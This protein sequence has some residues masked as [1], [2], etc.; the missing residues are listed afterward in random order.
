MKA[1]LRAPVEQLFLERGLLFTKR[2][3]TV[4][5]IFGVLKVF[6]GGVSYSDPTALADCL[7]AG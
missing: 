4:T 1:P 3:F 2:V 6:G 7:C 5:F